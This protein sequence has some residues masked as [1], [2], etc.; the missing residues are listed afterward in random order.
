M[1]DGVAIVAPG[2]A[3][4]LGLGTR[5]G[6]LRL[7]ANCCREEVSK[8]NYG[9]N[10]FRGELNNSCMRNPHLVLV[11]EESCRLRSCRDHGVEGWLSL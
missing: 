11:L 4:G 9:G 6:R 5:P 2:W 1:N 8:V 7:S 10:P 3:A